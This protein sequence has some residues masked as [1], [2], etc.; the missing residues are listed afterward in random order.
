[1][2]SLH[3]SFTILIFTHN[4]KHP[5]PEVGELKSKGKGGAFQTTKKAAAAMIVGM[6]SFLGPL[7]RHRDLHTF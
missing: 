6:G 2:A 7:L 3:C 5:K 4:M 1:M